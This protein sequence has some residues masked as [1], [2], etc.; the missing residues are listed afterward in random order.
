MGLC[1]ILVHERF[2]PDRIAPSHVNREHP[3]IRSTQP[4]SCRRTNERTSL[5]ADLQIATPVSCCA[6]RL[7]RKT[8]ISRS[9][10][11]DRVQ[12]EIIVDVSCSDNFFQAA[13]SSDS[14]VDAFLAQRLDAFL[15]ELRP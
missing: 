4:L 5:R 3:T 14:E 6:P 1:V 8:G 7:L 12:C 15:G 10:P 9:D 2:V 13:L 11:R